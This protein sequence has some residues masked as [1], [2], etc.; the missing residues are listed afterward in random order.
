MQREA[1]NILITGTPGVGK[2]TL[3]A[4]VAENTG[5]EHLSV[6]DFVRMHNLQ[7]SYDEARSAHVVDDDNVTFSYC[8]FERSFFFS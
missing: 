7:E 6:S 4:D 2:T 3:A 8:F 1:P 5:L